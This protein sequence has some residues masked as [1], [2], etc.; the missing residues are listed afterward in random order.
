MLAEIEITW[1]V[2][3][4]AY[5]AGFLTCLAIAILVAIYFR[6]TLRPRIKELEQENEACRG[7]LKIYTDA[8]EK[9]RVTPPQAERVP[10]PS[11]GKT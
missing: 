1:G 7:N 5:V 6:A 4:F 3:G 9:M 8:F 10:V 11:S 2:L